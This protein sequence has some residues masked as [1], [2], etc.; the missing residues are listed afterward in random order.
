MLNTTR[1]SKFHFNM[2]RLL[3]LASLSSSCRDFGEARKISD[4]CGIMNTY[5]IDLV[6]LSWPY[7]HSKLVIYNDNL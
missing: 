1:I 2:K 7:H 4:S 3:Q 5:W 6:L